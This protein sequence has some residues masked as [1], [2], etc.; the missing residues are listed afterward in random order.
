MIMG[1]KREKRS[2]RLTTESS[3][4]ERKREEIPREN[5]GSESLEY[6]QV[7]TWPRYHPL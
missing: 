6:S 1:R 7:L 2:E 5:G 3:M 4:T